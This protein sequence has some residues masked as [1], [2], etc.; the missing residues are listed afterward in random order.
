MWAQLRIVPL[1]HEDLIVGKLDK[2]FMHLASMVPY[3]T[4]SEHAAGRVD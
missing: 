3:L 2:A 4:M 1:G